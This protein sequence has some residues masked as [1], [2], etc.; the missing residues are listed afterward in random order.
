M[1]RRADP[2]TE[3][4]EEEE[5]GEREGRR[6]G[7]YTWFMLWLS[8]MRS[9]QCHHPVNV[10]ITICYITEATANAQRASC[11]GLRPSVSIASFMT[12]KFGTN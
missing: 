6:L 4:E 2:L 7:S 8:C 10:T 1:R 9:S 11:H 3:G 5:E 12:K